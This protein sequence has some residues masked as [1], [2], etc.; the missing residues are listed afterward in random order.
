[1]TDGQKVE[2]KNENRTC[3]L[4]NQRAGLHRNLLISFVVWI[5]SAR[6]DLR[7]ALLNTINGK[8]SLIIAFLNSNFL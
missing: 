5:E 1:M 2:M 6:T 7:A 3:A 4:V 8:E